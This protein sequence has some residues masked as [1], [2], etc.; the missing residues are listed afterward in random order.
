[1]LLQEWK[2]LRQNKTTRFL[3]NASIFLDD[4]DDEGDKQQTKKATE[5][6]GNGVGDDGGD[7]VVVVVD[8]PSGAPAQKEEERFLI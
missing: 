4:E 7:D 8:G 2:R 1:M 5:G 6:R 3:T